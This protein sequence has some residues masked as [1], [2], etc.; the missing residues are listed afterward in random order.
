MSAVQGW[1]HFICIKDWCYKRSWWG[2]YVSA[3]PCTDVL[4]R[5]QFWHADTWFWVGLTSHWRGQSVFRQLCVLCIIEAQQWQSI[6]LV[7][8]QNWVELEFY[9]ISLN[10]TWPPM[11]CLMVL[12]YFVDTADHV[13]RHLQ[14]CTFGPVWVWPGP[15]YFTSDPQWL[16][17]DLGLIVV[18][19]F[20]IWSVALPH[21]G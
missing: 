13:P 18:Q 14:A 3:H 5:L 12:Q 10:A 21:T 7:C 1:L 17:G 4:V 9:S 19:G 20:Q 11:P 16:P 2:H 8:E 6:G 15:C